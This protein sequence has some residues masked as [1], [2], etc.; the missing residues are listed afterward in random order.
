M[1]EWRKRHWNKIQPTSE[2]DPDYHEFRCFS[3]GQWWGS[4]S[5]ILGWIEHDDGVQIKT[6][7]HAVQ[8][9]FGKKARGKEMT[10]KHAEE[11]MQ[12]GH[13]WSCDACV[14]SRFYT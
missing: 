13:V 11:F 9:Q 10:R 4:Q 7:I 6:Q 12:N 14:I 8:W 5:F 2:D 1:I 3:C